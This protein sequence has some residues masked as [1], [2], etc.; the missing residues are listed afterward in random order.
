MVKTEKKKNHIGIILILVLLIAAIT[1]VL[2]VQIT[3]ITVTGNSRYTQEEIEALLFKGEWSRNSAYCYYKNRFKPHESIPF[4]EDYKIIFKSPMEVEVIIY[5]KSVVGYVVYMG[6][7]MYFDKD[8]IV[9]ESTGE[10]L[11]GIPWVTGLKFG[12]II[13]NRPLPVENARIFGE[14]LNLT[15]VLSVY[16]IQV[17]KIQYSSHDEA[18][19]FMKDVEVKL[20]NSTGIDGKVATLHDILTSVPEL[21]DKSGVLYLDTYDENNDSLMYSFEKK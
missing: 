4:V 10:K 2:S 12:E 19:L 21:L 13:L 5:E 1:L 16:E 6:S 3:K 20:G 8:G 14:I 9:V 18:T 11:E 7:N 17:D 15:Q